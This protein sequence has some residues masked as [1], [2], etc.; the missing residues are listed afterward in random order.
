MGERLNSSRV[1]AD[2]INGMFDCE[3]NKNN[4]FPSVRACPVYGF[5]QF[6]VNSLNWYFRSVIF[7]AHYAI[8]TFGMPVK[9]KN[10]DNTAEQVNHS[11]NT[12]TSPAMLAQWLDPRNRRASSSVQDCEN[13]QSRNSRDSD[14]RD[15]GTCDNYYKHSIKYFWPLFYRYT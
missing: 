15:L 2:M 4:H 12:Q 10:K 5:V 8:S 7:H 1:K 14:R 6:N 13:S 11:T 3:V 9:N